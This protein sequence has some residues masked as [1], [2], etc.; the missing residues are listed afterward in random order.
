MID[1]TSYLYLIHSKR[2]DIIHAY[3]L[4]ENGG[5]AKLEQKGLASASGKE[6]FVYQESDSTIVVSRSGSVQ[7]L[8]SRTKIS[9]KLQGQ[10]L[11]SPKLRQKMMQTCQLGG[12]DCQNGSRHLLPPEPLEKHLAEAHPQQ[13]SH[14]KTDQWCWLT[15]MPKTQSASVLTSK[16]LPAYQGEA[17]ILLLED[18]IGLM[19]ELASAYQAMVEQ[20]ELWMAE[21]Y[22]R[23]DYFAAA[24]LLQ[25]I[26]MSD[27]LLLMQSADNQKLAEYSKA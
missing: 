9:P 6:A 1:E 26:E 14:A 25:L 24:Q 5:V 13:S 22:N 16:I 8:Y 17:A 19:T 11:R 20:E 12:F 3:Q 27:D 23:A 21:G 10:L 18:P 7:V 15:Q 4:A 2:P